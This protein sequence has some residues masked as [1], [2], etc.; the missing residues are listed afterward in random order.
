MKNQQVVIGILVA[1][2]LLGVGIGVMGTRN[3]KTNISPIKV[4]K[5]EEAIPTVDAS[6]KV[7][8]T[9]LSGNKEVV[10]HID[11]ILQG[12]TSIEYTLSYLTKEQA[13]QGVIGTIKPTAD[14]RSYEKKITLGT[15]SSGTCVYHNV[16]GAI[17]VALKFTGAYGEKIFEKDFTLE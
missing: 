9:P 15:C 10:L 13:S 8:L 11:G 7:E 1:V 5:Q 16:Q 17:T 6:V 4:V 12:T 3:K 14:E 2:V